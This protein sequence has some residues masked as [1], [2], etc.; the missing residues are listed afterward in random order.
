[1]ISDPSL[2]VRR[3]RLQQPPF[4]GQSSGFWPAASGRVQQTLDFIEGRTI[5]AN[6]G[7]VAEIFIPDP[8]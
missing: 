3:S 8:A 5:G 1:M 6:A 4:H 7:I 2:V